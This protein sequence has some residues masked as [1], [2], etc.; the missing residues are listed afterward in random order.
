MHSLTQTVVFFHFQLSSSY[1]VY[2][3]AKK[4]QGAEKILLCMG[5]EPVNPQ[6]LKYKGEVD[7]EW[8]IHTAVDLVLLHTDLELINGLVLGAK[9]A[10]YRNVILYDILN[11]RSEPNDV[12]TNTLARSV[13]ISFQR[14][15]RSKQPMA[16]PPVIPLRAVQHLEVSSDSANT[17]R[18]SA[19]HVQSNLSSQQPPSSPLLQQQGR[20]QEQQY[21]S[22]P[23]PNSKEDFNKVDKTL[24]KS[25]G[26]GKDSVDPK[27]INQ[28]PPIVIAR[29]PSD[30]VRKGGSIP[31][32]PDNLPAP[33]YD[34]HDLEMFYQEAARTPDDSL[35]SGHISMFI[36]ARS[37]DFDD[38]SGPDLDDQLTFRSDDSG[39]MGLSQ[40]SIHGQCENRNE[41]LKQTDFA[42]AVFDDTCTSGIHVTVKN[43]ERVEE[44]QYEE[45]RS[46]NEEGGVALSEVSF[47]IGHN[48]SP[49]DGQ[50]P[51]LAGQ[52]VT[53]SS[54]VPKP[55]PRSFSGGKKLDAPKS[56]PK[57]ASVPEGVKPMPRPRSQQNLLSTK[58]RTPPPSPQRTKPEIKPRKTSPNAAPHATVVHEPDTQDKPEVLSPKDDSETNT[59]SIPSGSNITSVYSTSTLTTCENDQEQE[60]LLSLV[61]PEAH[62][63]HESDS[64]LPSIEETP[65]MISKSDPY[66]STS[67]GNASSACSGEK[68]FTEI[69]VHDSL[70]SWVQVDVE[71]RHEEKQPSSLDKEPTFIR[72]RSDAFSTRPAKTDKNVENILDPRLVQVS[73]DIQSAIPCW[74]CTNLTND[75]VC[76]VCGNIQEQN[77]DTRV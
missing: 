59:L 28:N 33:A 67:H 72:K 1:Y 16:Q 39:H 71:T 4:L 27:Y 43:V 42:E 12:L 41:S 64:P 65:S 19:P 66:P 47:M 60:S 58:V 20:Q 14:I 40:R 35:V 61:H 45:V 44:A 62:T 26:V 70:G 75:R 38:F 69:D 31:F 76:D 10:N 17:R 53:S 13:S 9:Q 15:A 37:T 73:F 54:P 49:A 48:V 29:S 56:D 21:T 7:T 23:S 36:D 52:T 32:D 51:S 24:D 25:R 55:R 8:V 57:P 46:K 2:Q 30:S 22:L 11:A 3:V 34:P 63:S 18:S 74:Y 68:T 5:Y 50:Q 6:E 77:K